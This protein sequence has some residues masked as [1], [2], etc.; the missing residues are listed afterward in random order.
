MSEMPQK[1]AAKAPPAALLLRMPEETRDAL[2][3]VAAQR[4]MREMRRVTINTMLL[5]VITSIVNNEAQ[6]FFKAKREAAAKAEAEAKA[7]EKAEEL[8]LSK[9]V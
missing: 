4:T 1:P 9:G 8:I 2:R 6:D 5:E 3:Y 7:V